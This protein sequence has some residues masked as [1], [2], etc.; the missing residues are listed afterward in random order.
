MKSKLPNMLKSYSKT[1][2]KNSEIKAMEQALV[3]GINTLLQDFFCSRTSE[4]GSKVPPTENAAE[5]VE[6]SRATTT[7]PTATEEND[8]S[9]MFVCATNVLEQT[10]Y[11]TMNVCIAPVAVHEKRCAWF[12][13]CKMKQK[14]CGGSR[15]DR[16][17]YY[18]NMINDEEF[19]AKNNEDK[20]L[21]DLERKKLLMRN[22]RKRNDDTNNTM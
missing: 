18:K 21:H 16:C 19:I 22:K 7:S 6:R 9:E 17:Q 3:P 4:E 12:P 2:A 1:W 5:N 10:P 8:R 13:A 20:R 15:R 11:I 14:I